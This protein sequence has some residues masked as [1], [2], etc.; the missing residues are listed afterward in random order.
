MRSR[1]GF[2]WN[3]TRRVLH[4]LSFHIFCSFHLFTLWFYSLSFSREK[5]LK[6]SNDSTRCQRSRYFCLIFRRKWKDRPVSFSLKDANKWKDI[7]EVS[8]CDNKRA[9]SVHSCLV[10]TQKNSNTAASRTAHSSPTSVE[11]PSRQCALLFYT[12]CV[13]QIAQARRN[14]RSGMFET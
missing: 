7:F 2:N 6:L 10:C 4:K 8:I 11:I 1:N 3:D 12:V 13:C 14:K 9:L 5:E